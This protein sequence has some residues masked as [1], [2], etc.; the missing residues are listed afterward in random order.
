MPD[1]TATDVHQ[2]VCEVKQVQYVLD[3][4]ECTQC[5]QPIRR[6]FNATRTAI[7]IALEHPII[8]QIMVSVHHCEACQVYFRAQPPFMRPDAIYSNR[9][10]NKAIQSVFED[11]M[12]I[13]RVSRRLARDFWVCPSEGSIR[14]WCRTYQDGLNFEEDYQPWVV[15]EFSGILCVDEVYQGQLALLLAVDP[16]AP[17]GDRL[18]GYQLEQGSVDTD[19]VTSFLSNLNEVGIHPDQVITDGSHLYPVVLSE[20]WPTAVHQL[21]LFHET[22]H[23]TRAVREALRKIRK[24]LP[25]PPPHPRK[26]GGGPLKSQSPS[27]DPQDPATQ[28]WYVRQAERHQA[29]SWVHELQ[30]QG[31]SMRAINR[32]T[33]YHRNTVRKWLQQDIPTLVAPP[34][35]EIEIMMKATMTQTDTDLRTQILPPEPWQSWAEVQEVREKLRTHRFLFLYRP[36]NLS[37][38]Q[39][40]D[41]RSL[42]EYPIGAQLQVI[43]DFV[44]DWYQIWK[45]EHG[46]RRTPEAAQ[47]RFESWQT[48]PTYRESKIF[49]RIQDRITA[50]RFTKLSHFLHHPAWEATSNGAERAG[51]A[52]RHR[53]A[54]HFN[55]RST[56]SIEGAL[57]AAAF[58]QK[59]MASTANRVSPAN[60]STRGRKPLL[61]F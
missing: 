43:R 57:T 30:T 46:T 23:I 12:A 7:D 21:C 16:A 31:L 40:Q 33:G 35:E 3:E 34:T 52:F 38:E 60:R 10:M 53:Q 15:A 6:L 17:D 24:E 20:V 25:E 45:D 50:E 36:Q 48:K 19:V 54:P 55:L 32:L 4:I 44:V 37:A 13:R 29:I 11:G 18:V 2:T 47:K 59:Q 41:L 14:I 42:L 49:K 56:K 28:R 8:L 61:F 5:Q 9:V 51:R 39:Q 27:S 22:R 1:T 26:G 58:Q